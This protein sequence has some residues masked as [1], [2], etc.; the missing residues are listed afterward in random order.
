MPPAQKLALN[1]FVSLICVGTAVWIFAHVLGDH[2]AIVDMGIMIAGFGVAGGSL[3]NIRRGQG[4]QHFAVFIV[5]IGLIALVG[6]SLL[7][8]LGVSS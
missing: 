7:K 3:W 4:K 1:I 6:W 8:T 2:P 5:S